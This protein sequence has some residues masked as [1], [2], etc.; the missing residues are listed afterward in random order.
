[1]TRCGLGLVS[2]VQGK[3][4]NAIQHFA[5]SEATLLREFGGAQFRLFSDRF[6]LLSSHHELRNKCL[7]RDLYEM[8]EDQLK[9][10]EGDEPD[11]LAERYGS[12]MNLEA[13]LNFSSCWKQ[14]QGCRKRPLDK[15]I[16]IQYKPRLEWVG[17]FVTKTIT[18]K[19]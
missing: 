4:E 19:R 7:I 2:L 17:I 9:F 15:T 1:M 11:V 14:L 8:S 3:F 13:I 12:S 6:K 16:W 18:R 5:A 10:F